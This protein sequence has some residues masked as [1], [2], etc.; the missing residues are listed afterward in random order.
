MSV[1]SN[2]LASTRCHSKLRQVLLVCIAAASLSGCGLFGSS[3]PKPPELQELKNSA[4]SIE[5]SAST[6]KS[7][8]F[9]FM[10]GFAEKLVYAA[11]YDDG[12][13]AFAEEGGREVARIDTKL[14]LAAGVGVAENMVIAV[15]NKGDVL[16]VD[17][18]GRPLWKAQISGEVLA[19]PTIS[20]AYVLVRTADG[21]LFALNRIDGIRKWVYQRPPP[22]LSLRTSAGVIVNRGTIYAG[23]AGGKVVAIELDSGKPTWE[24]TISVARGATELERIAD[25]AGV[26][27]VDGSRVCAAVY[28][29]RTGCVETLNGNILWSREIPSSNGVAIDDKLVYVSDTGGNV[30]ALDKT[31][32]ATLWKQEKLILREPGTPLLL[33]GKVLVGDANG[34]IHLLS[35]ENG[36]L[37]GRVATDGS[38]V[39]ALLQN[40]GRAIAQTARGGLF[41]LKVQ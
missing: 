2:A 3:K 14:P 25:V 1:I 32:G 36:E 33:N 13:Y 24:A 37:I 9:N 34:L 31:S 8:G 23:F 4:V 5:W 21:R 11:S 12:I 28:Q 26:P 18:T 27:V 19:P 30:Y 7:S 17:P 20:G 16:A 6:G 39:V 38:R 22:S 41:S 15:S 40:N 35:P 10:P 29:G